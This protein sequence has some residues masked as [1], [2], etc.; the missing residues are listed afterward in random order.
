LNK[1]EKYAP[2][3]DSPPNQSV[4]C[5]LPEPDHDLD[6]VVLGGGVTGG[7]GGCG[8]GSGV[9]QHWVGMG[10]CSG[11][12]LLRHRRPRWGLGEGECLDRKEEEGS[13]LD[14]RTRTPGGSALGG[15]R[16]P[17]PAG[18]RAP[19]RWTRTAGSRTHSWRTTDADPGGG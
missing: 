9:L 6:E 5:V 8:G 15:G 13:D 11:L 12:F 4:N 17:R 1:G 7:E 10:G 14:R 19:R 3:T 2:S 18:D 16:G